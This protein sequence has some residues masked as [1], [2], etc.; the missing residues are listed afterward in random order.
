[1]TV[2]VGDRVLPRDR[3]QTL[4]CHPAVYLSIQRHVVHLG[5][6]QDGAGTEG[7]RLISQ[8]PRRSV[9]NT[10]NLLFVRNNKLFLIE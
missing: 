3:K 7:E 10:Q 4:G 5:I 1:M 9:M 2:S 6:Q 8:R